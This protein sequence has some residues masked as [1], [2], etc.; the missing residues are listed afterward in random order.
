MKTIPIT[1]IAVTLFAPVAFSDQGSSQVLKKTSFTT[2]QFEPSKVDYRG[3]TTTTAE[4]SEYRKTRMV[5][6]DQFNAMS[7]EKGTIILD[8]RS[9][10][11]FIHVLTHSIGS[12]T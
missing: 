9:A 7:Q 1:L 3:F 12:A 2:A 8:T 4:V 10:A 5:T 6:L 11:A